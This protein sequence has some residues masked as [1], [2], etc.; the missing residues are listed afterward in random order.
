[1]KNLQ[2]RTVV[3]L[4]LASLALASCADPAAEE[5]VASTSSALT[6]KQV[7]A[8]VDQAI[9]VFDATVL[10]VTNGPAW[11]AKATYA[12]LFRAMGDKPPATT[13]P[14]GTLRLADNGRVARVEPS[15]GRL[16]YISNA[17]AWTTA[18]AGLP[19][20]DDRITSAAVRQAIGALG[21]PSAELGALRLD[22]QVA[23]TAPAGATTTKIYDLY[24][25]ANVSRTVNGLP[26]IGSRV[27]AAV[28]AAG[29]IQRMLVHWPAFVVP[30]GLKLRARGAVVTDVVAAIMRQ[31]PTPIDNQFVTAKLAY[32]P[33]MHL[34]PYKPRGGVN[35]D[36]PS[37]STAGDESGPDTDGA[38]PQY[39]THQRTAK[40]T[41]RYVPAVLVS[42]TSG[43]TPYQVAVALAQ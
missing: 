25:L 38:K 35:D 1:M 18:D 29:D 3:S 34:Q 41:V 16:R 19:A 17:R 7:T 26:V 8:M 31:D 9:P 2:L 23:E 43:E 36:D 10:R 24:R 13:P 40:V 12:G 14:S 20:A 28:T 39:P 21:L 37:T 27:S 11:S 6:S 4:T 33:E 15:L 22:T 5:V 32:V 30:T 42:V